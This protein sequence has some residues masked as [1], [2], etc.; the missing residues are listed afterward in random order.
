MPLPALQRWNRKNGVDQGPTFYGHNILCKDHTG[1][2][3][4][5][6]LLPPETQHYAYNIIAQHLLAVCYYSKEHGELPAFEP[7]RKYALPESYCS[8]FK[9]PTKAAVKGW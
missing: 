1:K 9:I 4:C 8:E 7:W 3:W 2:K 5:G 6:S